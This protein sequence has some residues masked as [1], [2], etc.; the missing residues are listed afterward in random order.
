MFYTAGRMVRQD[1]SNLYDEG[2]QQSEFLAVIPGLAPG[3]CRLPYRYPPLVAIAMA[4]CSRLPFPLAFALFSAV[5]ATLAW[6]SV[7]ML[8]QLEAIWFGASSRWMGW[9]LLGWPIA[10]ETILG[11]QQAFFGL[12]IATGTLLLLHKER[13]VGAGLV[14]GLACYKPNLL[15]FFG[16]ALVL[17]YPRMIW[18]TAITATALLALQWYCVGPECLATYIQTA[19]QLATE[20]WGLE[21]PFAKV[22][23]LVPWLAT[24]A[25]NDERNILL[26]VGLLGSIG[27]ALCDRRTQT[28]PCDR[29]TRLLRPLSASWLVLWNAA[30]NPYLPTY[31]LVMLAIPTLL[32]L[33]VAQ[34]RGWSPRVLW[35]GLAAVTF[36]PHVS[37]SIALGTGVQLFP[38]L[39]VA[40]VLWL[41][42]LVVRHLF[43]VEA[44]RRTSP[45]T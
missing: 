1:P 12:A 5:S 31:D 15:L 25:P 40:A 38:L 18:G 41:G 33:R 6:L 44:T 11:G 34:E 32:V 21:T 36:G 19:R 42:C 27:W 22:H 39:L 24:V 26:A 2:R 7:A 9:W 3:S 29:R 14:L 30:C 20:P 10:I 35:A 45:A 8:G 13:D 4:P 37:Q 23:G 17:R 16:L 28:T 43:S